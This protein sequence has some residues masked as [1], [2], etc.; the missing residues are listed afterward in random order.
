MTWDSPPQ[1]VSFPQRKTP[2][3]GA[4]DSPG[5]QLDLLVFG[6][7][8]S[9][10]P[11]IKQVSF[12]HMRCFLL[13]SSPH[14]SGF[15]ELPSS[16]LKVRPWHSSGLEDEFPLENYYQLYRS[17]WGQTV[18]LPDGNDPLTPFM[19]NPYPKN[20][21]LPRIGLPEKTKHRGHTI[22]N[23]RYPA[24]KINSLLVIVDIPITKRLVR[25]SL[26]PCKEWEYSWN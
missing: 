10:K 25:I 6:G 22:A 12:N 19:E 3:L 4:L 24:K 13:A 8:E 15:Y 21:N 2:P 5:L 14:F 23:L 9:L 17:F 11:V 18:N 20:R 26:Y 1:T 16:K 7:K